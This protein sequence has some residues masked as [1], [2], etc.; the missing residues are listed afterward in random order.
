MALSYIPSHVDFLVEFKA[1]NFTSFLKTCRNFAQG[2]TLTF[3]NKSTR[4][5]RAYSTVQCGK[6]PDDNI[7]LNSDFLYVNHSC[8]PNIAF[9][10]SSGDPMEWHIR[11][12]KDINAGD[13]LTFFY[14]STEWEMAQAFDCQCGAKGCMGR[15]QGA[16]F[17]KKEDVLERGW[18]N[19]W[20]LELMAEREKGMCD[21]M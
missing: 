8:E 1:G 3:L 9:D 2:E 5:H 6:G 7:E 17:M 19:P 14:P 10:L 21:I 15:I 13:P 18:A 20:I 16:K 12:L 4:S 11:A